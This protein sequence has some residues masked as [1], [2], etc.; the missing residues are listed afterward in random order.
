MKLLV[1]IP[2]LIAA[3]A[4]FY[5]LYFW[6]KPFIMSFFRLPVKPTPYPHKILCPYSQ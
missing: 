1:I 3:A 5:L 2:E 4:I 6:F